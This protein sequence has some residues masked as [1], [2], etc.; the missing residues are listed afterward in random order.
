MARHPDAVHYLTENRRQADP[1]ESHALGELREG[2]VAQAVSWYE[3][4][5][6][7]HAV[8]DRDDAIAAAVDAWAADVAAGHD[9]ALFAWRRANVAALNTAARHWMSDSGRLSGPELV[10]PGGLAYRAGDRVVTLAP[11]PNHTLVTSQRATVTSVDPHTETIVLATDD[12]RAVTLT[13]EETGADRLGYSY[14]TTVHR[15][16]GQTVTRAHLYADGGGRELAYVAISRA[17]ESTHVWVVADDLPTAVEDLRRDWTE[18]KTPTWAID[19]GQPATGGVGQSNAPAPDQQIRHVARLAAASDITAKALGELLR[20]DRQAAIDAARGELGQL[21][22]R[23]ADLENGRGVYYDSDAG[24]AVRDL[25]EARQG[26]RA[27][28]WQ[29]EHADTWLQRR[30]AVKQDATWTAREADAS[31]R[32]QTHYVPEAVRL[33][34][35]IRR[36]QNTIAALEAQAEKER[37]GHRAALDLASEHVNT[38]NKLTRA[39]AAYRDHLDGTQPAPPRPPGHAAQPSPQTNISPPGP[40]PE[41]PRQGISM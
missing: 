9:A 14:A 30:A 19:T 41:P 28:R 24:R 37:A 25:E 40:T 5:G 17:R 36:C 39:V 23:Q 32:W 12:D 38:R 7:V 21:T 4:A 6:R 27:A 10:C 18:R 31:Q 29:A 33:D 34:G 3:T 11:G 2:D 22:R 26:G 16:Q 13:G 1:G 35:H 15:A 20:P 8:G